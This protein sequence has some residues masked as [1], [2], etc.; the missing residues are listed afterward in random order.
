[1]QLSATNPFKLGD[2]E[3]PGPVV[4]AVML[5]WK[6]GATSI[7]PRLPLPAAPKNLKASLKHAPN[8]AVCVGCYRITGRLEGGAITDCCSVCASTANNT[9]FWSRG[10]TYSNILGDWASDRVVAAVIG[11]ILDFNTNPSRYFKEDKEASDG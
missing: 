3:I 1:M 9:E 10:R 8:W 11:T 5:A 4:L 2:I 6:G 7:M